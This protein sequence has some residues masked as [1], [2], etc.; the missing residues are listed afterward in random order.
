MPYN[1]YYILHWVKNAYT[2]EYCEDRLLG[3]Y[4]TFNIKI[5]KDSNAEYIPCKQQPTQISNTKSEMVGNNKMGIIWKE[6]SVCEEN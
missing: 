2:A 1:D 6:P 5:H 4:S 3:L